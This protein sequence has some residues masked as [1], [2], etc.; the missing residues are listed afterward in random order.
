MLLD[1]D[2]LLLGGDLLVKLGSPKFLDSRYPSLTA[3]IS[4]MQP[5]YT[6][7]VPRPQIQVHVDVSSQEVLLTQRDKLDLLL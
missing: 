4:L 1:R 6:H 7:Q 2:Y 5:V 3:V